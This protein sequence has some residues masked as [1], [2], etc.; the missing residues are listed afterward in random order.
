V[1]KILTTVGPA[2][3]LL[4]SAQVTPASLSLTDSD[5]VPGVWQRMR[6]PALQSL[7]VVVFL[8]LW[9]AIASFNW[10]IRI[11]TPLDVLQSAIAIDKAMFVKD[12]GLSFYRVMFGFVI[13]TVVGIPLGIAIGYSKLVRNLVFPP[14]EFLRPVPPIAWIPL[15]FQIFTEQ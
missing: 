15:A 6:R 11:P 7:S 10:A 9:T 13:A 8:L 4:K 12:M 1:A 5:V 2:S 3:V 14:V